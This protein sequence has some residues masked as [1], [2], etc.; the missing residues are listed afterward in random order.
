MKKR[1]VNF[2][3]FIV[4]FFIMTASCF[5]STNYADMKVYYNES[6]HYIYGNGMAH[7]P[8]KSFL[9]ANEAGGLTLVQYNQNSQCLTVAD[10]NQNFK[11]ISVQSISLPDCSK[12]GGFYSGNDYNFVIYGVDSRSICIEKYSKDWDLLLTNTYGLGNTNSFISNDLDITA[13]NGS[14][15]IVTNHTMTNGHQANLRLQISE[16]NLSIRVEQSGSADYDGYCSHSYVPEVVWASGYLYTLD[17]CDSFPSS[18]LLVSSFGGT[19]NSGINMRSIKSMTFR[20]WGNLGNSVASDR[21][22]LSAYN[23]A[24]G[25][26]DNTATD[27]YLNCY[28]VNSR[29]ETVR[30]TSSGGAGTPYVA[31]LTDTTGYVLWNTDV[32][33]S[34]SKDTLFFAPYT[35]GYT[36][37]VGEVQEAGGHYLSDCEPICYQNCLVWYTVNNNTITFHRIDE[38]GNVTKKIVVDPATEIKETIKLPNS[39][40]R[41]EDE[42]FTGI[43]AEKVIIPETCIQIG[44][45]AFAESQNLLEIHIPAT[46]AVIENDAFAQ[47][48]VIIYGKK[49]SKAYEYAIEHN[50]TF[51]ED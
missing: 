21:S 12:W 11:F 10:F 4:C 42:A 5:A 27:I 44:S 23:F 37:S 25:D 2:S 13:G 31:A 1:F 24:L 45:R 33:I 35:V 20:D 34:S 3:S 26:D 32:Y 29:N 15:F 43:R 19:L 18:G 46:V 47:S 28:Q 50:I 39:L 9:Y 17:R 8:R 49:G 7:S 40:I 38:N 51:V 30:V 22:V 16:E 36:L 6:A 14:L 48:N 41:I